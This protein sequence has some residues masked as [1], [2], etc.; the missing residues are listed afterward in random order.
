MCGIG[1]VQLERGS[2]CG[3]TRPQDGSRMDPIITVETGHMNHLGRKISMSK[4]KKNHL[5]I[6]ARSGTGPSDLVVLQKYEGVQ[7]RA[8]QGNTRPE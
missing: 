5:D 6:K 2:T 1:S 4:E 8:L 3:M 7:K